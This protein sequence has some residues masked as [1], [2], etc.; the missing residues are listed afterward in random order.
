MKLTTTSLNPIL[1]A[2]ALAGAS[3]SI[4][5]EEAEFQALPEGDSGIAAKY[6]D[7]KGIA[8]DPAVILSD[9]FESHTSKS[10]LRKTWNSVFNR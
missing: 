9:D 3:R 1:I 6:P 5:Q 4:A 10:D 2:L 7:D 8:A